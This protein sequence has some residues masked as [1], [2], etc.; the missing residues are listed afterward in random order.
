MRGDQRESDTDMFSYIMPEQRVPQDHPLRPIRKLVDESLKKLSPRFSGMYSRYGRPSI[1]PEQLFR[2][3]LLQVLYTIR[4][5][6]QLMEQLEFNILFRWFVGVGM[7]A[8][9]WDVTVFSKNRER[10]LHADIAGAFFKEV[11]EQARNQGLIS[12]EHFS[13]DGTLLEA[14]ASHKSFQKKNKKA[15]NPPDHD[16]SNPMVNFRGE[17]RKNDTHQS[18]TDPDSR[19]FRKGPGREAKLSYLG[20]A[21]TENRNGLLVNV[22]VSLAHGRAERDAALRLIKPL[23]GDGS[24]ITLGG[25]KGYDAVEFVKDLRGMGVTPHLARKEHSALDRRTTRHDGYEVSQRKRKLIEEPFG[26]MKTIGL[27]HKLRHRGLPKVN[28][29]FTFTSAAYNLIRIR[30]LTEARA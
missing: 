23:T 30:N 20:H 26:W 15:K 22:Q 25:D 3:L 24:R 1:P 17:R 12:E 8:K 27:L 21:L 28:W 2:A 13:V 5:E 9:L 29:V 4:S 6:R 14:W 16:P 7:D 11:V 19:L 18:T 10:M